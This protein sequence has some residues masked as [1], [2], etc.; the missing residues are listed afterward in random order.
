MTFFL[1]L[2]REKDFGLASIFFYYLAGEKLSIWSRD[3]FFCNF[4][5]KKP[6]LGVLFPFTIRQEE[7]WASGLA[8]FRSAI[9]GGK[10][11][12]LGVLFFFSQFSKRKIG[13]LASRLFFLQFWREKTL[14]WRPFFY[15]VWNSCVVVMNCPIY[16]IS[17]W[18]KKIKNFIQEQF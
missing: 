7:N 5:G 6:R 17:F 15:K 8:T 12:R 1:Q 9:F 4:S 11:P 13:H 16:M 3:L 18:L 10:K 14:T 2:W